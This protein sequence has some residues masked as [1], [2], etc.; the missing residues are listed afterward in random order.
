MI[1]LFT[2]AYIE[3]HNDQ[4]QNLNIA[5]IWYRQLTVIYVSQITKRHWKCWN[6]VCRDNSRNHTYI[7]REEMESDLEP[8]LYDHQSHWL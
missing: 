2:M 1:L 3:Q 6:Q 4:T 5:I 8:K 7:H